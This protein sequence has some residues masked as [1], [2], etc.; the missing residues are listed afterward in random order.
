M[1]WSKFSLTSKRSPFRSPFVAMTSLSMSDKEIEAGISLVHMTQQL[2]TSTAVNKP[3]TPTSKD[4]LHES[5][6]EVVAKQAENELP[7]PALTAKKK[8]TKQPNMRLTALSRELTLEELRPHFGRPIVEVAREFGICTTFL[9]K[10]CRRCGIKRWPHRQIRSLNRTIQMLE[11]V[12]SMSTS[13]QDKE[14]YA[15][16][17]EELKEKQRAVMEDPDANGKLKGMKKFATPKGATDLPSTSSGQ[18]RNSLMKTTSGSDAEANNLSA[19]A[20]AVDSISSTTTHNAGVTR[21][22]SGSSPLGVQIPS[23][24]TS[25]LSSLTTPM[26]S[27]TTNKIPLAMRISPMNRKLIIAKTDTE[28]R[29]RSTSIGSL[30]DHQAEPT[31]TA[32]DTAPSDSS[33]LEFECN[34]CLDAVSSPV[35]T[36]C[37]HL[38]CWPCLYQWMRNHSECPVCKA[39]VSEE[40]VI[41]VYARGA[42]AVDP[43]AHQQTPD[44]GI[45]HRPLGQRPDAEQLRRRRP[46]NFGI[47]NGNGNAFSMSPTVGFFPT[48]FGAPYQPPAQH[49]DGTPPTAQEARQQMQQAFLSRFLL[50]VGSLVILCLISF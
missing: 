5:L 47:F 30:Q 31:D 2:G 25:M 26:D 17:I 40:N 20:V 27:A 1:L 48:L 14:R 19:L 4:A 44:S 49:Q 43:R 24:V 15:A 13:P 34:I 11:Q 41:P 18:H 21:T 42:E 50:I 29:L 39:G 16:Q 28:S 3:E 35:V 9:K 8:K 37:G 10:I 38:Y 12:E 36:L 33:K 7:S 45:P 46:Y 23:A 22:T 6:M 32:T